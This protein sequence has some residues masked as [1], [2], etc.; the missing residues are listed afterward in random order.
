MS[1]L[2][3]SPDDFKWLGLSFQESQPDKSIKFEAGFNDNMNIEYNFDNKEYI[4]Y[5][6]I[7]IPKIKIC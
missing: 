6:N 1:S 5:K 2:I 4:W 7:N 3:E